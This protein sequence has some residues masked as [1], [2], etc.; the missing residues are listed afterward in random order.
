MLGLG[1]FTTELDRS[2][3]FCEEKGWAQ[4]DL[5]KNKK[6][7]QKQK[8]KINNWKLERRISGK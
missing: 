5:K 1:C 2:G 6:Q 3:F 4:W 7:K 8:F